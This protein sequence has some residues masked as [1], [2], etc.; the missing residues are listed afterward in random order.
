MKFTHHE[1]FWVYGISHNTAQF[2]LD[3]YMHVTRE[4]LDKFLMPLVSYT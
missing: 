1:N 2:K 3:I 4:F